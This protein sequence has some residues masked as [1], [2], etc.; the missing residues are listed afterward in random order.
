MKP[1]KLNRLFFQFLSWVLHPV[2]QPVWVI[3]FLLFCEMS[4]AFL[5]F[6]PFQ[7]WLILGQAFTL[8]AFFPLVTVGLLKALGFIESVQLRTQR[9]R[10]IPLLA[11]GIWYFWIWY[12]WKNLPDYPAELVRLTLAIWT[13]S[14]ATLMINTRMK[15]SLH[16]ISAGLMLTFLCLWSLN[17]PYGAGIYLP[18][19]SLLAGLIGAARFVVSDHTQTEVYAGYVLGISAMLIIHFFYL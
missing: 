15:I 4:T 18:V 13:A 3:A 19:A 7:R 14:W 1:L 8:Y 10:V 11:A 12:V 16:T 17:H 5:G 2:F 6:R 9:E